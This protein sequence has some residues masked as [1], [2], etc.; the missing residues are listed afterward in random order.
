MREEKRGK[1]PT[2]GHDVIGPIGQYQLDINLIHILPFDN[3][4]K[5]Y[6]SNSLQ[7]ISIS[8]EQ[9]PATTTTIEAA[10]QLVPVDFL[11][12]SSQLTASQLLEMYNRND[13][14]PL[15]INRLNMCILLSFQSE[16]IPFP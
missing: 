16:P 4:A 2:I 8:A 7:V 11:P 1:K 12:T 5:M 10:F 15:S 13:D 9:Q 14:V 3:G 6:N